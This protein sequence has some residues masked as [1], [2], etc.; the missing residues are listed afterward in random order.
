MRCLRLLAAAA[1]VTGGLTI[2]GPTASAECRSYEVRDGDSWYGIADR[3]HVRVRDLLAVNGLT[4]PTVIHPGDHLC[5]P[6][7]A[8]GGGGVTLAA[9]P[10]QGPCWYGDSWMAPRGNGRRHE[11]VDMFA[12]TGSYVYAVSDGVLTRRAWDQPGLRSGNA[13]WLT[14][15]DGT[16]FYYGHLFDFAPGLH[17]GDRVEAG[18][19][20]GFM[21]DT[22]RSSAPH[23]HFEVHPYGGPPVDPYPILRS[24][25][26]CRTGDGYEQPNGWVP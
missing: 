25:G 13:W 1:V 10:M 3:T 9:L 16:Y 8:S 11:G 17:V 23:L 4:E 6:S 26:G 12:A 21:G 15:A 22:G 2:A 5:L 24:A 19:I 7:T 20:I 18:E 14:R